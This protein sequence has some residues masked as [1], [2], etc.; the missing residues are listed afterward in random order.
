MA[1]INPARIS[2]Q[3]VGFG[4][5]SAFK[6]IGLLIALAASVA[7]G[8]AVALWGQSP[9]Y[10]LL[11]SGLTQKDTSEVIDSLTRTG[12]LYQLDPSS[13]AVLVPGDQVQKA[14]MRLAAEGLPRGEGMGSDFLSKGTEFG[15]SQMMEKARF[16]RAT[17]EDLARTIATFSNVKAAR[18]HIA[19]PKQSVFIRNRQ[20][21][22]ASVVLSLYPGRSFDSEN[23]GAITNLVASSVPQLEASQVTV[24][25]QQGRLLSK[26]GET[27]DMS[28]SSDQFEYNRKL[29]QHYQTRI[30]EILSPIIGDGG[31]RAQVSAE[32]DFTTTELTEE[33]FNPDLP[34]IRSEQTT[35]EKNNGG[36]AAG[37]VPGAL[38]NQPPA[39]GVAAPA[40]APAPAPAAGGATAAAP[41][42]APLTTVTDSGPS[43]TSKHQT[44][45]YELDK[46]I[47]HT[48]VASGAVKRLTVAVVLDDKQVVNEKG[49]VTKAKLTADE[50]KGFTTIIKEAVGFDAVRGD[51]INVINA[52]FQMPVTPTPLPAPGIMEQPWVMDAAKLGGSLFVVLIVV[53][54][55]LRPLMKSLADNGEAIAASSRM[56][57][58]PQE[59]DEMSGMSNEQLQLS[60]GKANEHVAIA[61]NYENN[62]ATAKTLVGQDPQRV[63]QV[64]KGWLG[65]VE[66]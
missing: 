14:R 30:E 43:N 46:T 48:R 38:S 36:A 28:I 31:V 29:E 8:V 39:G 34:S 58:A 22:T 65:A 12:V 53:F 10:S 42:A 4:T 61:R 44:R 52:A 51:R 54:G 13:G 37:G 2:N 32:L 6:Q 27:T 64:M 66:E 47:S 19:M 7:L 18:V 3:I 41:G 62:L 24:V 50:I 63:A 16:D 23:V 33:S 45:N 15:T 1:V 25:D 11:Y 60:R 59:N 21:P 55:V 9:N 35:E 26:A 5:L 40:P 20:K 57:A 49:E 17:E 56:I